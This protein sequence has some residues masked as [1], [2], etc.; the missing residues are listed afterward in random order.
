MTTNDDS[1][2][3][4]AYIQMPAAPVIPTYWGTPRM[5]PAHIQVTANDAVVSPTCAR[6]PAVMNSSVS[7]TPCRRKM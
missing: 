6:P 5:S 2:A 3:G 1:T 4:A 7:S